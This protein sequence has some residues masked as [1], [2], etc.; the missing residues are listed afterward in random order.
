MNLA[1]F[2]RFPSWTQLDVYERQREDGDDALTMAYG[3]HFKKTRDLDIGLKY[4]ALENGET[5]AIIAFTTDGR[6]SLSLIHI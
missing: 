4:D 1:Y 6:L 5:D 2:Y 3:F